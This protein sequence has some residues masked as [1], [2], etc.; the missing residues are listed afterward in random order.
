MTERIPFRWQAHLPAAV[1]ACTAVFAAH[2]VVAIPTETFYGLAVPPDDQ[3]ALDRLF[4]L[5]GRPREKAV[6]VVVASLPQAATLVHLPEAWVNRL[7]TAWPA[8]LTVVLPAHRGGT[9][10]VRVPAHP[11]LRALLERLGPLTATSANVAGG[12]PAVTPAEVE[13]ALGE[14]LALILD[15]GAAPGGL[16]STLLDLTASP[17]RLLRPGAWPVDPAWGVKVV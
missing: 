6:P 1:A 5:K 17:P 4:A 13:E 11:L 3:E 2:G 12:P 10:A 8:P 14:G 16:P 9:L 7:A 15:G